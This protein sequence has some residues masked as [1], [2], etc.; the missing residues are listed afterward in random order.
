MN[1]WDI[2]EFR[3]IIKKTF[4][5]KKKNVYNKQY[6]KSVAL[7][8]ITFLIYIFI[9]LTIDTNTIDIDLHDWA[10][11]FIKNAINNKIIDNILTVDAI[12]TTSSISFIAFSFIASN[13]DK[14]DI[15]NELYWKNYPIY[16]YS[17]NFKK[18]SEIFGCNFSPFVILYLSISCTFLEILS[19]LEISGF[20]PVGAIFA[21]VITFW[22]CMSTLSRFLFFRKYWSY[23]I[24]NFYS[25]FHNRNNVVNKLNATKQKMS[26]TKEISN[27][28][29][30]K[31]THI[32]N[33]NIVF[34]SKKIILI[35]IYILWFPVAIAIWIG[36]IFP[37]WIIY[38]LLLT[39]MYINHYF[40]F[41]DKYIKENTKY[42]DYFLCTF[43]AII[44]K[45]HMFWKSKK[46]EPDIFLEEYEIEKLMKFDNFTFMIWLSIK[47]SSLKSTFLKQLRET[48]ND[49]DSSFK[50]T[51][52]TKENPD[53]IDIEST[54]IEKKEEGKNEI[55]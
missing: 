33:K 54:T 12:L 17:N 51:I 53:D 28:D 45:N 7:I 10:E 21:S 13:K 29:A 48:I 15:K 39:N 22:C 6:A 44:E 1:L 32:P 2:L 35:F 37:I 24:M 30:D 8:G 26:E 11:P 18:K 34:Y 42:I 3:T 40:N 9:V 23:T 46:I 38:R 20:W 27:L 36:I 43:S 25:E 16:K 14:D 41:N 52:N 50:A 5:Y 49:R 55:N 19:K 4:N 47:N 31:K